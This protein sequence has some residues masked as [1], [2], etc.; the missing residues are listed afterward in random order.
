MSA[1]PDTGAV[2]DPPAHLPYLHVQAVVPERDVNLRLDV[3]AGETVAILGPNGA[4]KSTLLAVLAGL[5]RSEGANGSPGVVLG[6]RT[7][8]GVP[9][10][11]RGVALLAQEPLLFPHLSALEN[12]AFS[13]R[14]RGVRRPQARAQARRY[15]EAVGVAELG[16][17]KPAQLSGGQAQRVAIARALAAQPQLLL[18]DE[19]MA[20]LDVAVTPAL[21]QTLRNVLTDQTALIVTHE[22]LD[23]LLLADRVVVIDRGRIVEDGP[24]HQV[25]TTPR[26]TFAAQLAGLNLVAGTWDGEAVRA[27]AGLRVAGLVEPDERLATGDQVA[28][29]FRPSAVSIFTEAPGG[30][31]R[32]HVEV[33]IADLEPLG[34][35]VRVRARNDRPGADDSEREA[36]GGVPL[37]ADVTPAA[38]AELGLVPG[39]RVTFAVKATEVSVYPT[40]GTFK[41]PTTQNQ[42]ASDR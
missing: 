42:A 40:T 17:R 18:L 20:A 25:L 34:D 9:P 35:R 23:A 15:L 8:D 39:S 24:T 31:P 38:V 22:V 3:A 32:N 29:L 1:V 33:T 10:H 6:G 13:P 28:A 12:V 26:S 4:G 14:A 11:A 7:L 2:S 21:R 30:S 36:A 37:A 27:A 5:I 41:R 19:P 16:R